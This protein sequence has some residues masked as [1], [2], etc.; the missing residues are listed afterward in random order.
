MTLGSEWN[1]VTGAFG[2]TGQYITR[3]LL[4]LGRKVRTL[5]RHPSRASPFGNQVEVAPLDFERPDELRRALGDANTLFNTYWVRFEHGRVTFDQAV[6]NT[7]KLIRAAKEAGVRRIVHLSVSN[8]AEDSSLPYFRGKALVEEAIRE[9]GLSYAMIRPTVIF[10]VED[11]LINNIA[12]LLRRFPIFA[13]P[14]RGGYRLQP[15]FV[16]DVA[17]LAVAAARQ[18]ED[19]ILD[20]VGPEQFTFDEVV[21]LIARAVGSKAKIIHVRPKMALWLAG[22]VGHLVRD[23]VLT[24]DEVEGLMANLLVS[25][26]PPTGRTRFSGWLRE[27]ADRVGTQYASELARHF[28]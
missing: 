26:G 17:E 8:P 19:S 24:R 1:V 15:V 20:A 27:N 18:T 21:R 5:A 2:F 23:V 6:S 4:S 28:R 22:L 3:R 9:S 11:I 7:E 13:V 10:G 16:E 14:G 25:A 12:W